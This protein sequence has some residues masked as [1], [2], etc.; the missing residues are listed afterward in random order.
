MS[1][2]SG[3]TSFTT[4]DRYLITDDG[5]SADPTVTSVVAG[6]S[7]SPRALPSAASSTV[8][9]CGTT[10]GVLVTY[11]VTLPAG[12]TRSV[13]LFDQLNSSLT[14]ATADVGV[15]N[16]N[17]TLA[18]TDF[19]AGLSRADLA[20]VVNFDFGV[21]YSFEGFF[22]PVDN[23]EVATNEAKAGSAIPMKFSLGGDFGLDVFADGYPNSQQ[24]DCDSTDPVDGIEETVTA[25]SS[26]LSYDATTDEYTYVWKTNKGWKGTCR[27][28][29]VR[30]DDGTE[31]VANFSFT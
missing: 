25:G 6:G 22:S 23:P 12:Q 9:E 17:T 21:G 1:T 26:G 30:L 7:G 3:D 5:P 8:F 28:L 14:E 29:V 24:I 16:D 19:L 27:Q 20:T 15:F 10:D 13:L 31:H 11:D 4:S 18:D 2:S